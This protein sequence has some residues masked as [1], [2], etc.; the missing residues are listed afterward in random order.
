MLA[1]IIY[2]KINLRY[3]ILIIIFLIAIILIVGIFYWK[4]GKREVVE[5]LSSNKPSQTQ[6]EIGKGQSGQIVDST[7]KTEIENKIYEQAISTGDV[8][9]CQEMS[10][11]GQKDLCTKLLA[12]DLKNKESCDNIKDGEVVKECVDRVNY[13]I[14]VNDKDLTSCSSINE[15]Y[16]GDSCI[17]NII[18]K[19]ENS[20]N[21]GSCELLGGRQKD[22]CLSH[23]LFREATNTEDCQKIPLE[24][25]REECLQ[26]ISSNKD[27]DNDGL[28]DKDEAVYGTD[29]KRADT[30]G[31]G[32]LDGD[33]I[34][35]GYNPLGE[36]KLK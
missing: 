31:D 7:D 1:V 33:E 34:K 22:V 20:Y 36:G 6:Q 14:A 2:M 35:N 4:S 17:I 13:E 23:I 19:E 11:D 21:T 30:D 29:P 15:E 8:N 18:S 24:G 32:Y 10:E 12:V 9:K 3:W 27:S 16:L 26:V 5:D 25:D 28:S